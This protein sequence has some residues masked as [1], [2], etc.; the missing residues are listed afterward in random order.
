[1]AN[2]ADRFA[3]AQRLAGKLC[4]NNVSTAINI[5]LKTKWKKPNFGLPDKD[6]ILWIKFASK[7]GF[8]RIEIEARNQQY[9]FDAAEK[10][11]EKSN[12]QQVELLATADVLKAKHV[13]PPRVRIPK[14]F[15][16]VRTEDFKALVMEFVPGQTLDS[17]M[18]QRYNATEEPFGWYPFTYSYMNGHR[19]GYDLSQF[20]SELR[21]YASAIGLLLSLP[22]PDDAAPGPVGGG[23]SNHPIF[24]NWRTEENRA[25]VIYS[26]V[27]ELTKHINEV[28]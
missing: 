24:E 8:E 19:R 12:E 11:Y 4:D 1:M 14:L 18:R 6:S 15:R 9:I 21:D 22:V 10:F 27:E 17:L 7:Y 25:P 16:V 23:Y 13:Q 5:F 3:T 2:R 28:S 26:S 20:E